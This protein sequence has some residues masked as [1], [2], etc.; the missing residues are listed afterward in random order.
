MC[1]LPFGGGLT[2]VAVWLALGGLRHTIVGPRAATAGDALGT[3][4]E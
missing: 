4:S 2:Y 3:A 1:S